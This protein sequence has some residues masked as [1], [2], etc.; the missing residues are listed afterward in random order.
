MTLLSIHHN[1]LCSDHNFSIAQ[2]YYKD[3]ACYCDYVYSHIVIEYPL[4]VQPL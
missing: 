4:V 2:P 3:V 1:V